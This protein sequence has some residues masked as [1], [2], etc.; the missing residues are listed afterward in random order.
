MKEVEDLLKRLQ[1]EGEEER[2]AEYAEK[3]RDE[4]ELEE[5][6]EHKELKRRE[7][8]F[9]MVAHGVFLTNFYS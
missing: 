1:R 7:V 6:A 8:V 4:N 3:D 2:V 5:E 9:S